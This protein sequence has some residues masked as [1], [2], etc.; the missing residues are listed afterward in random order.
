MSVD[1]PTLSK[2]ERLLWD[3]GV[4]QPAHIDLEAIAFDLNA[5]VR[6]RRLDGCE[7]RI[8]VNGER[9]LISV[10]EKSP[11]GRRRFSLAHELAHWIRD[12][13]SFQCV[14]DDIGPQNA[15]ARNAESA[16][17]EFAS[18]LVLPDYL[19]NPWIERKTVSLDTAAA[20]ATDFKV[21]LTAAAIKLVKRSAA[22]A[23]V[24][25]YSQ[26]RLRWFRKNRAF[27]AEYFLV[28]ELHAET[29][30]LS[31]VFGGT[32]GLSRTK[33]E[34]AHRWFTGPDVFR[35]AVRSQSVK[36]PEGDVLTVIGFA[37]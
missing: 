26:T 32:S 37:R 33:D 31:L 19:V 25:C 16:A 8:V 18:Q 28:N 12:R 30:A 7:A 21:S 1:P 4:A 29:D 17:N 35:I 23:V 6:Y 15:E 5:L 10:N 13:S 27:P 2:A 36:L 24:A 14:G 9:A 22:P 34:P 20:L 11:V 3:Y